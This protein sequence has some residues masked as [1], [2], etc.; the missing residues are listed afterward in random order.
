MNYVLLDIETTGALPKDKEIIEIAAIKISENGNREV[1]QSFVKPIQKVEPFIFKLTHIQPSDLEAAPIFKDLYA[2]LKL[3]FDDSLLIAHNVA[4]DRSVLNR[5]AERIAASPFDNLVMDSADL[6]LILMP[7]LKKQGLKALADTFNIPFKDQH[8][9]LAD[10]ECLEKVIN[11]LAVRTEALD[12]FVLK[13]IA[14]STDIPGLKLWFKHLFEKLKPVN[15]FNK[16]FK[17]F[18]DLTAIRELSKAPF[19]DEAVFSNHKS[20]LLV[21]SEDLIAEQFY[22]MHYGSSIGLIDNFVSKEGL[23]KQYY[24]WRDKPVLQAALLNWWLLSPDASFKSMHA[25]LRQSFNSNY[26]QNNLSARMYHRSIWTTSY[27]T[28]EKKK[29]ILKDAGLRLIVAANSGIYHR[30][31]KR[32]IKNL[33]LW[34][35][36]DVE[37]SFFD[38]FSDY[39]SPQKMCQTLIE[40]SSTKK[41]IAVYCR[42]SR[43]KTQL[44][45][46]AKKTNLQGLRDMSLCPKHYKKKKYQSIDLYLFK[47]F[48]VRHFDEYQAFTCSGTSNQKWNLQVKES[49]FWHQYLNQ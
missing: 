19:L 47:E 16:A 23:Q 33:I 39:L 45:E 35:N 3:F 1:F 40:L 5:E 41:R 43:F 2:Q 11:A 14:D 9:A 32:G 49:K 29:S 13:V 31:T 37:T 24:S 12:P 46:A 25:R 28:F 7:C 27:K 17:D 30:L 44:M 48:E 6:S 20:I 21:F 8:R 4:F 22:N 15:K 42:S 10:V 36:M 38:S 34:P 18:L 26:L